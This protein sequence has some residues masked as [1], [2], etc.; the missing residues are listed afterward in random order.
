MQGQIILIGYDTETED[1]LLIVEA[2]REV[3][4][5]YHIDVVRFP[6]MDVSIEKTLLLDAIRFLGNH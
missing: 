1:K 6:Q 4:E 2:T 5:G 3:K